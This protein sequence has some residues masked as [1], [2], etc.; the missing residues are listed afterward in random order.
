MPLPHSLVPPWGT[1]QARREYQAQIEGKLDG[2]MDAHLPKGTLSNDPMEIKVVQVNF[3]FKVYR[4]G[5]TTA[6]ISSA[7]WGVRVVGA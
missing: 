3:A 7:S 4:S 2:G 5:E 1:M 6:H